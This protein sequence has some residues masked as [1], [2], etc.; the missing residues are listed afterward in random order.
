M[1]PASSG[2]AP[3]DTADTA[4][5]VFVPPDSRPSEWD[6]ELEIS[7]LEPME[8]ASGLEAD[9]VYENWKEAKPGNK[10][11]REGR[12]VPSQP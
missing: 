11:Q 4:S 7:D 2:A 5:A 9:K 6:S 10:K 12:H 8:G 1:S 3:P